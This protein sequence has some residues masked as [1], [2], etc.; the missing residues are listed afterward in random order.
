MV[1]QLASTHTEMRHLA[2]KIIL[3]GIDHWPENGESKHAIFN[4]KIAI[5][6]I[7]QGTELVLKAYLLHSGYI[8]SKMKQ[9]KI[10]QGIKSGHRIDEYL[11]ENRT[12]DFEDARQLAKKLL[13]MRTGQHQT[14]SSIQLDGLAELHKKR[15]E[16]QHYGVRVR[17]KTPELV[18]RALDDLLAIYNLAGYRAGSFLA[19]IRVFKRTL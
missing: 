14:V 16:I 19:Q 3:H 11:D 17:G 13:N 9:K 4:R 15:N 2:Q 12:L 6:H 7:D 10:R 1:R 5:L 18:S 8:I